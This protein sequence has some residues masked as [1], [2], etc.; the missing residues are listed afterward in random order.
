MKL[1]AS[2]GGVVMAMLIASFVLVVLVVTGAGGDGRLATAA[3][4]TDANLAPILATIRTIESGGD[5]AAEAVGSTASG[6]YQFIDGTWN[7]YGGYTRAAQAP[8]EQQDQKAAEL[9]RAVLVEHDHSVDAVPVVWYIGHLPDDGAAEW[10][11]IPAPNAGNVLTPREYQTKWMQEYEMQS[12]AADTTTCTSVVGTFGELPWSLD[13][14]TIRWGGYPN[15]RIPTAAMRYRAHSGY[16]HPD[17][18][19]SYDEL[20]AAAQAAGL[21]LRGSGYRPSSAGGNTAGKSCH[22]LGLA[23]D[24]NVLVAGNRYRTADQAFASAEFTW[25]CNNAQAFGWITPRW[26]IPEGMVCGSIVGTGTGGNVG[27]RCC[28]LEPWHLE[29]AGTVTAHSDFLR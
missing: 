12:A 15:G 3:C 27:N 5:Y 13:C 18:S 22:G 24:I 7:N 17:A 11:T 26:A 28:F 6:A 4:A 21:D 9:I 23:I 10:D 8:P 2:A 1:I 14:S 25:L 20:Y 19:A 16:L 29:A